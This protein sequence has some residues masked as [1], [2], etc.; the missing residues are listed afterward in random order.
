[1]PPANAAQGFVTDPIAAATAD[2]GGAATRVASGHALRSFKGGILQEKWVP[3]NL[4]HPSL[5]RS[6]GR[7]R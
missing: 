1:M 5:T 7:V 6:A 3:T 4:P 2:S